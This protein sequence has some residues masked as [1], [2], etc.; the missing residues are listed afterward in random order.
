MEI[1]ADLTVCLRT[2]KAATLPN[3]QRK[4]AYGCAVWAGNDLV[5]NGKLLTQMPA[6]V[7]FEAHELFKGIAREYDFFVFVIPGTASLWKL[8]PQFDD[9]T[10]AIQKIA[11]EYGVLVMSGMSCWEKLT[12][13]YAEGWHASDTPDNR[14]LMSKFLKAAL[15]AAKLTRPPAGWRA[16]PGSAPPPIPA[17]PPLL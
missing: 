9:H 4:L 16:D 1:K 6:A 10:K 7:E 11:E 14:R 12:M 3:Q 17:R 15:T 5:R 8:P 13:T 2:L